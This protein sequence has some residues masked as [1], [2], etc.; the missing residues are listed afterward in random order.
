MTE[1]IQ[2]IF[3]TVIR[4][5][6]NCMVKH[7][8]LN[9]MKK[10]FALVVILFT[11]FSCS[12]DEDESITVDS[13]DVEMFSKDTHQISTNQGNPVYT[14]E[15]E[16]IAKVSI[17]GLIT[18]NHIGNTA[19]DINGKK[20]VNVKVNAKY[21]IYEPLHDFSL[22]K[23]QIKDKLGSAY[24]EQD[25]ALLYKDPI[26]TV[27]GE[28]YFFN[29]NT[30]KLNGAGIIYPTRYFESYGYGLLERYQALTYD[31]KNYSLYFIDALELNNAKM[32]V[33]CNLYNLTYCIN[34]YMLKPSSSTKAMMKKNLERMLSEHNFHYPSNK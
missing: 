30:G 34:L 22:T 26:S 31:E 12:K 6:I 13:T 11:L 16:Y 21:S 14:S 19:I 9:E 2:Y 5:K 18:A 17:S 1:R 24:A 23:N 7:L 33:V 27:S 4:T 25:T 15:N 32:V 29:K 20:M 10:Y 3:V 8:K 28:I